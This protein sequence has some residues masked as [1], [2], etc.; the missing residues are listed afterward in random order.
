MTYQP[1]ALVFSPLMLGSGEALRDLDAGSLPPV[2]TARIGSSRGTGLI[3][4]V[5]TKLRDFMYLF[6]TH[7]SIVQRLRLSVRRELGAGNFFWHLCDV[8]RDPDRAVL[9]RQGDIGVRGLSIRDLREQ[10][11]RYANWYCDHGIG[12]RT[13]VSI[14]TADGLLGVRTPSVTPGYVNKPGPDRAG[15]LRRLFLDWRRGAPGG[16]WR[17][18]PLGPHSRR[19]LHRPG[20]CGQPAAG[21]G[22]LTETGAFDAAV[23]AV[24]DPAAYGSSRPVAVLLYKGEAPLPE[25]ALARCNTVLADQGMATLAALVVATDRIGLPVGMAGKVLKRVLRERH[26]KLLTEPVPDGVALASLVSAS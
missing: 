10:V 11:L 22:W 14:Y 15:A 16:R 9:F 8:A 23:V 26:Q 17:L 25:E 12:T 13:R 2:Y 6:G 19:D 18:V 7:R 24:D 3:S 21:R 5:F 1:V 20:P 4:V